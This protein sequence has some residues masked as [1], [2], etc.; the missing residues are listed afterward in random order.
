MKLKTSVTAIEKQGAV[1][2][3][4]LIVKFYSILAKTFSSNK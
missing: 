4:Y 3:Q 1:V 2:I